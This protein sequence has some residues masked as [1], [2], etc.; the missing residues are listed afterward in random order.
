MRCRLLAEKIVGGDLV[1]KFNVHEDLG[2]EP[3]GDRGVALK[4]PVMDLESVT[5]TA[6]QSEPETVEAEKPELM[7]EIGVETIAEG[8]DAEST[9]E[10][11][12]L[13]EN[14]VQGERSPKKLADFAQEAGWEPEYFYENVEMNGIP[15]GK[16]K[17]KLQDLEKENETLRQE[18]QQLQEQAVHAQAPIQQYSEEALQLMQ[19][20]KYLQRSLDAAMQNGSFENMDDIQAIKLRTEYRDRIDALTRSAQQKQQEYAQ[21]MEGKNRE[22]LAEIRTQFRKSIPEWR[23]DNVRSREQ[24]AISDFLRSEGADQQTV[25]QVMQYNPWAAKLFRRLWQFEQAKANAEKAVREVKKVPRNMAPA[26]RAAVA[27]KANIAEVGKRYSKA[28][29]REQD[30]ILLNAD[31][32][33]SPD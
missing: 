2:I 7:E 18:T 3:D 10:I 1:T 29:R 4:N 8:Q 14:Q 19:D 33:I 9:E 21:Q 28:G 22:Y 16:V 26:A 23:S 11:Q 15:M 31:L 13:E 25:D 27:K 17:D 30:N 6:E 5:E 20:A 32:G 24:P 12:E